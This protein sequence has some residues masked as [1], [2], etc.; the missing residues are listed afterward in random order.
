V[1]NRWPRSI[2]RWVWATALVVALGLPESRGASAGQFKSVTLSGTAYIDAANFG[3]SFGLKSQLSNSGRKLTLK[4]VW[5]TLVFETDNRECE[6]NGLRVFL[7]DPVR[8]YKGTVRIS[9]LDVEKVLIPLLLAG[10]DEKRIPTLKT[11]VLDPGHGGRDPGNVNQ[12]LKINEKTIALDTALRLERI[13]KTM[14]YAV[15]M[16]RSNDS[17]LNSDKAADL[18]SRAAVA[19]K[20][21]ADLFISLHYNAV[22]SGAQRVTGVEVYTLTPHSQYSTSD[23][24][25]DDDTGAVEI[26]PGNISDHWNMQLGYQIHR[27]MIEELRAPDRGLKRARWAVLRA[28]ECPAI[29]IE[30]GFLSNDTEGGKIATP[31]YRQK[32]A[33]AIANGV[34][35]YGNVLAGVHKQRDG[36]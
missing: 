27:L 17:Q 5:S 15:V 20:A 8:S 25:R 29:L 34:Q 10:N 19:N 12:R 13:L 35:A 9:R 30:A 22:G 14:G 4:S 18:L 3:V 7:G 32:I 11:I 21:G 1:S 28:V 33:E 16:T 23:S 26:N 6:I 31:T 36:K 24:E 2:R